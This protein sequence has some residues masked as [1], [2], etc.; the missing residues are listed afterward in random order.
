MRACLMAVLLLPGCGMIEASG[1]TH[2]A[3][4]G[5]TTTGDSGPTGTGEPSATSDEY[6]ITADLDGA[7]LDATTDVSAYWFPGL[8]DGSISMTGTDA[9]RTWYFAILNTASGNACAGGYITL[10]DLTNESG[11]SDLATFWE[12][13][14]CTVTVTHAALN[15]GDVLE[16]T[17]QAVLANPT[18]PAVTVTNGR[19]RALRGP[20]G[21]GP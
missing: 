15:I 21:T 20:D 8:L 19:F 5:A 4:P 10:D 9:S 6:F 1:S 12:G 11:A 3:S 14:S 16:G 7:T 13:G 2:E 18:D 17:F